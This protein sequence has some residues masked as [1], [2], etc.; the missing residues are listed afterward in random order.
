MEL[1]GSASGPMHTMPLSLAGVC[2]TS[3]SGSVSLLLALRTPP[4]LS[5]LGYLDETD[6]RVCSY[7]YCILLRH[8]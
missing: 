8:I 7:S 1:Q 5:L 2:E 6:M 4:P 3:S